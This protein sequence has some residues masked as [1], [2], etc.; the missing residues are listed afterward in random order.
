[1]TLATALN[2]V[3]VLDASRVLAGPFA[4]QLLADLG[5]DVIKIE[6]PGEGDET[7]GWGPPYLDEKAG[8]SA[9]FLSCNRSKRGVTLDLKQPRGRDLFLRLAAKS[10]VVIENFRADSVRNLGLD[11]KSL[12]EMNP[13]LV[14]CSL[15]GFGRTGK[16]ADKSGYD[17]VVQGLSGMMA[18]TGPKDGAPS[19]FG[20]AIADIVTGHYTATAALA[21]LHARRGSGHG[22]AVEITLIDSAVATMA[23]VAQAFLTSGKVSPRQGNAHLQIVPYQA[24]E[25]KDSSLIL[26]VGNDRQWRKFASLAGDA[27]LGSDPAF[28]RNA[29]R[30]TNR[31]SLIPRLEKI[32]KLRTTT[33]W[34]ALLDASKIPAGPVWQLD[35]LFKSELAKERRLE[36]QA[37]RP[38]G[39]Q[40]SLLRS[41]LVDG[42][43]ARMPP[44]LGQ[45]TE[46]VLKEVLGASSADVERWRSEGVL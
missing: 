7:R 20:V 23:N 24:F 2:G 3:R 37:K 19:K 34:L 16:F 30:V 17:F 46:E 18:A 33:E 32:L 38:D 35:Q 6:Q 15:S 41:P 29:D 5:A 9:Y 43:D 36:I 8:L 12:H 21:G 1:M 4:A 42:V 27:G 45:H 14:V 11:A 40:V 39:T 22:Y 44:D 31:E 13:Q 26:A 28:A 25:T 10:D